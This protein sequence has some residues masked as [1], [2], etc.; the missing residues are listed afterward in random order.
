M[1][2]TANIQL[3]GIRPGAGRNVHRKA[4]RADLEDVTFCE[5]IVARKVTVNAYAGAAAA[6]AYSQTLGGPV[7]QTMQRRN[8]RRFQPNITAPGPAD[9][10][11]IAV[12]VTW[13]FVHAAK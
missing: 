1:L 5:N 9:R 10:G 2:P 4:E 8:F 11:H 12:E 7:Q 6:I 13:L 3:P